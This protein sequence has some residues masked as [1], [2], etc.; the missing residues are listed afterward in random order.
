MFSYIK[1]AIERDPAARNWLEVILTYPGV[2]ALI[3]HRFAHLFYRIG[4]RLIA[5][6]IS[7]INRIL[8][9]VEIHPGAHIADGV[10]IDHG[11]GVVIGETAE[12]GRNVTI[13][14]GVTLGGV[15]RWKGKRHPTIGA[16]TVI[17]AGAVV[18]GP[19]KVG[20]N[21]R[22]GAGSVVVRDVEPNSTVVGVPARLA[23]KDGER[24]VVAPLN[25]CDIPD[26]IV[27]RLQRLQKEIEYVEEILKELKRRY[28]E[29][30]RSLPDE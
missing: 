24:V 11:M 25:H 5:R 2:H 18:L 15:G 23:R 10:F 6:I 19:V 13:F 17:G 9:G 28:S 16:N 8:T 7:H 12:V 27:E 3:L 29:R 1:A 20:E 30:L 21:V 14:Q 4:L 26:P 22:I